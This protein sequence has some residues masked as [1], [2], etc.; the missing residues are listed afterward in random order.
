MVADTIVMEFKI[1]VAMNAD[2]AGN[3]R[4]I[5]ALGTLM[6][7]RQPNRGSE[8][9]TRI[10]LDSVLLELRKANTRLK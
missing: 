1:V 8:L 2:M 4:Y 10:N 6:I 3:E 9:I 7:G 5:L